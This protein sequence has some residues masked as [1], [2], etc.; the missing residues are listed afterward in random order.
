VLTRVALVA[1]LAVTSALAGRASAAEQQVPPMLVFARGGDIYRLAVD[2][3]ETVRLTATK[4]VEADP[5]VSADAL[6]IA[7]VRGRDG[8][9][10]MDTQGG[11]SAQWWPRELARCRMQA[12][13]RRHGLPTASR[14]SL[15]ECAIRRT[16]SAAR[17]FVSE[18]AVAPRGA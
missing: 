10:A 18:R 12:P 16:S 13:T 1:V 15:V 6:S 11:T 8:L 2:G 14:S 5:A 9:W 7:F 4:A 17:S 3:S